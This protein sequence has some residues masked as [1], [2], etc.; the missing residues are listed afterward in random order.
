MS[1][2]SGKKTY[3]LVAFGLLGLLVQAL[4][5]DISFMEFLTSDYMTQLLGLLG[6]GTIRAG[7][8]KVAK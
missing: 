5:G 8:S 1:W 2:L 3:F 7:I 6:L 4:V